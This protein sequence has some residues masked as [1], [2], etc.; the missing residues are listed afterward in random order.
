MLGQMCLNLPLLLRRRGIAPIYSLH[1][2]ALVLPQVDVAMA[3]RKYDG[4]V[5]SAPIIS[6]RWTDS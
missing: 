5:L 1:L 4:G 2:C 6:S 3:H